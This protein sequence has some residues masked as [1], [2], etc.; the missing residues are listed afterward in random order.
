MPAY[1]PRLHRL[2]PSSTVGVLIATPSTPDDLADQGAA[3]Q[4][5]W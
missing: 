5:S 1:W 2:Q 3:L 4:R